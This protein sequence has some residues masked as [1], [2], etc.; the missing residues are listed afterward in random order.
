MTKTVNGKVYQTI[1]DVVGVLQLSISS[2]NRYISRGIFPPPPTVLYGSR[3]MRFF[4]EEWVK[5][6]ERIIDERRS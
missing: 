1:G 2:I 6:A 4:P 3:T 5:E